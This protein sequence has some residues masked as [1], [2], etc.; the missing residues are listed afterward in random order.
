MGEGEGG[1]VNRKHSERIYPFT[2]CFE[3]GGRIRSGVSSGT[4]FKIS[5]HKPGA[6]FDNFIINKVIKLQKPIVDYY[7]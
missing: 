3:T 2:R 5:G 4:Q 6:H 7:K 1:G